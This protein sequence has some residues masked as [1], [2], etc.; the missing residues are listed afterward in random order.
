MNSAR[1][2]DDCG[3]S[4]SIGRG[5]RRTDG[6]KLADHCLR[7]LS[8]IPSFVA[9][10]SI[11]NATCDSCGKHWVECRSADLFRHLL[12]HGIR[13]R[14]KS[15]NAR[16][17][18]QCDNCNCCSDRLTNINYHWSAKHGFGTTTK[19]Q[20]TRICDSC[21][22]GLSDAAKTG[23][24]MKTCA[25]FGNRRRFQLLWAPRSQKRKKGVCDDCLRSRLTQV[26]KVYAHWLV[27]HKGVKLA[28][29]EFSAECPRVT[30]FKISLI[31][32]WTKAHS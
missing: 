7:H 20:K 27:K 21:H 3:K 9:K 23:D 30:H 4:F 6:T 29:K 32:H 11:K 17:N 15:S 13:R 8:T 10:K 26:H 24:H 19:R 12:T 14:K 1:V 2:C 31:G 5:P 28:P 18:Y 22:L 16:Q 25:Y